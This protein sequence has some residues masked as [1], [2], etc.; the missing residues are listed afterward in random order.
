[1]PTSSRE[2]AEPDVAMADA[3]EEVPL[4]E[5]GL[6]AAALRVGLS[7]LLPAHTLGRLA[8]TSRALCAAAGEAGFWSVLDLT[9]AARPAAFFECGR[10]RSER[11][12]GVL[13]LRLQ[14]CDQ[15]RDEHLAA[16]PPALRRL[17]LDACHGVSDA[18]VK[19]LAAACASRLELFSC[20][21]N[22]NLTSASALALGLRCPRLTSLSLSGCGGIDAQGVL[23]LASRCRRLSHLNLTRLPLVDDVALGAV[24]QANGSTLRELRLFAASQ[25]SD[26]PLLTAARSCAS[27]TALDCTGLGQLTDAVPIALGRGC[28]NLSHVWLTWVKGAHLF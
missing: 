25:Y 28:P 9:A 6:L 17:T 11:F 16:L 19:A 12:A 2:T 3:A 24:V 7:S 23:S 1:M 5:A 20:Y 15:I 18:G 14:F 8:Q 21:W 4:D 10:S 27:L 13:E 26:T 22:H